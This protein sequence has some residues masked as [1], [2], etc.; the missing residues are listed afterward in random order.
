[1]EQGGRE[2][3]EESG[4]QCQRQGC[5]GREKENRTGRAA[6]GISDMVQGRAGQMTL[7]AEPLAA[8]PP[9]P[10]TESRHFG[11]QIW[12]V[13]RKLSTTAVFYSARTKAEHC[14]SVLLHKTHLAVW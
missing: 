14:C 8:N 2:V 13:G 12:S 7:Q 6:E 9:M 4:Y 5:R 11:G 10:R 3:G 1:M